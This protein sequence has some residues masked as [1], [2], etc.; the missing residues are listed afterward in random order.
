MLTSSYPRHAEDGA[1]SFVASLAR[2]LVAQGHIV[3]V[4]APYD[5]EVSATDGDHVQVHRFRYAPT[6]GLHLAGHGRALHA[7]MQLKLAIPLLMPVY[8]LACA[9]CALRLHRQVG[10][11]LIHAHWGV[12]GGTIGAWIAR[13]GRLPLVV[14]LHGSDVYVMAKNALAAAAG[15]AGL[16]RAAWTTACSQDLLQRAIGLGLDAG[17]AGVIPYGVDATVY[18]AGDGAAMRERLDIPGAA[19]VIGALGRLVAK[20]GFAHLIDAMP[21]I[22]ERVPEA[23]CVIGGQGDLGCELAA[24]ARRHGLAGRVRFPGHVGWRSTPDYY[25]LCDVVAVPSIVDREGNVDGLPNVVLEAMASG[26]A[27]VASRVA[28][29]PDVV[30]DGESGVLVTPGCPDEL[31]RAVADL[32]LD[33]PR[34]RR[35]GLAAQAQV[36][37]GYTWDEVAQA[38][39]RV[40]AQAV[41]GRAV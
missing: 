9:R 5:P 29:I 16:R 36:A 15:R 34:R 2:A 26:R 10:F 39:A 6:D 25:A 40:Y 7:D 41:G 38:F 18:A 35:L 37:Q 30:R 33:A 31:A 1:G 13:R 23:Y 24:Q 11:D 21:R 19:P 28:G 12:P 32:M 27:L 22:L 17:K 3:H 4:V 14:S 20:K 8:A